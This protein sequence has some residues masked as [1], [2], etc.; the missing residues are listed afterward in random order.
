[1]AAVEADHDVPGE[2]DPGEEVVARPA[3]SVILL[4]DGPAGPEVLL[5]QRNPAASFMPGAWVFPGGAARRDEGAE[6]CALRELSEEAAVHLEGPDALVPFSHWITPAEVSVR[7]D[8]RFFAARSPEA[9]EPRCDGEECV[10]VRWMGPSD[11]LSAHGRGELLLV[12][13][14]IKHLERLARYASVDEALASARESK[15]IPV[16]PRLV[17]EGRAAR[18]VLPAG[19]GFED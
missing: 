19:S 11:A 8:T 10:A 16:Q 2:S 13:P 15:I 17:F 5:V 7:F 1:V 18:V 3:A 12:F 9:A 4:R 6:R 14:T